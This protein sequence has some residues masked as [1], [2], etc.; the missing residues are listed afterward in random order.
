MK[1]TELTTKIGNI[2]AKTCFQLK[3]QSPQ[4]LVIGGIIGAVGST[5]LACMATL[6][7]TPILEKTRDDLEYVRDTADP[8]EEKKQLALVYMHTGIKLAQLYLPA[9][10]VGAL[11]IAGIVSGNKILSKRNTALAAA[12]ATMSGGFKEYRSRVAD[13]FGADVEHELRGNT[14]TEKIDTTVTGEDGKTKKTKKAVE[15][16]DVDYTSDYGRFFDQHT[17][18]YWIDDGEYNL[19]MVKAQQSLANNKLMTDG[20]LFLNDVYDMLGIDRTLPGQVVG[21]IY[22]KDKDPKSVGDN[23]VDFGIRETYMRNEYDELVPVLFLDFNV[24]GTIWGRAMKKELPT[25]DFC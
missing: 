25:A 12:Y 14:H 8:E 11:S 20:H 17:S 15:V 16:T 7:V 4:I 19:T 23:Y 13:R 2:V 3:K 1:K 24:D 18:Q 22:D 21:W 9:V 10:G 6:K 5:V